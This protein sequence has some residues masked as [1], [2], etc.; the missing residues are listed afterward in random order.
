MLE[1]R[2]FRQVKIEKEID[3]LIR[4]RL[5][6]KSVGLDFQSAMRKSFFIFLSLLV[7]I[8]ILHFEKRIIEDA[9]VRAWILAFLSQAEVILALFTISQ[10]TVQ[11]TTSTYAKMLEHSVNKLSNKPIVYFES[12]AMHRLV[13]SLDTAHFWSMAGLVS[14]LGMFFCACMFLTWTAISSWW[15]RTLVILELIFV[16]ACIAKW[17][18]ELGKGERLLDAELAEYRKLSAISH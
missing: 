5:E 11:S 6:L 17:L 8:G 10:L 7:S 14:L 4:E 2:R 12:V 18:R 1:Q 3:V 9:Q 13:N 16:I 15:Y